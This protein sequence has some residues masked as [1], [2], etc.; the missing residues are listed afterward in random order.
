MHT[1]ATAANKNT[2]KDKV[3]LAFHSIKQQALK[4]SVPA[5]E[6]INQSGWG[7][8]K[9]ITLHCTFHG[10]NCSINTECL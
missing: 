5:H 3:K 7:R 8:K 4:S 6:H 1:N 2:E 10:Y 9:T